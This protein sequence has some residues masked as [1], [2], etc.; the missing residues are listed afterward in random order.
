MASPETESPPQDHYGVLGVKK[1]ANGDEIKKAYRKK[2]REFHPDV[3]SDPEAEERFKAISAAYDTLSDSTK[4][5]EHD[6]GMRPGRSQSPRGPSRPRSGPTFDDLFEEEMRHAEESGKGDGTKYETPDPKERERQKREAE[7]A[8]NKAREAAKEAMREFE[9]AHGGK[10]DSARRRAEKGP[11][12][13]FS[14][15]QK[16][17]DKG[18]KAK[19]SFAERNAREHE[20]RKKVEWEDQAER[21]AAAREFD[22]R[23]IGQL[24]QRGESGAAAHMVSQALQREAYVRTQQTKDKAYIEYI[25]TEDPRQLQLAIRDAD[26]NFDIT[27]RDIERS[28]A[29]GQTQF[30]AEEKVSPLRRAFSK[31]KK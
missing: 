19:S 6:M 12:R 14:R 17:E 15:N 5:R 24:L 4:R 23:I 28:R 10:V 18:P 8:L 31:V 7:E 16:D 3:N 11:K 21:Q 22:Q 27:M 26:R 2:A 25:R 13:W 30:P 29:M 9:E 20:G 1:G